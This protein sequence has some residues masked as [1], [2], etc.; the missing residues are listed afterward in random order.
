MG[1]CRVLRGRGRGTAAGGR[2]VVQVVADVVVVGGRVLG[3][4]EGH[5]GGGGRTRAPRVAAAIATLRR[6]LQCGRLLAA[7]QVVDREA[8]RHYGDCSLQSERRAECLLFFVST[9]TV[10]ASKL[11]CEN[12]YDCWSERSPIE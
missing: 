8:H 10:C 3:H 2:G 12:N 5:A 11:K 6:L 4:G 7:D 9:R 1:S